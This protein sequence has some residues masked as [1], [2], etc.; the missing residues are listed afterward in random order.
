MISVTILTYNSQKHLKEVLGA[1][2]QFDQVIILD[3][4]SNDNTLSIAEQFPNVDIHSTNLPG[5]GP[6]HNQASALARN[7]WILSLDSDEVLTPDLVEELLGLELDPQYVYSV[8]MNNYFNGK[9]IRCCGWYP[10]RHVRLYNRKRTS[11]TDA[12]VH[13]GIIIAGVTEK[14]LKH[15]V[16]HYS[17][18]SISDFLVKMERYTSL[19]AEQNRGRKK[20]SVLKALGHGCFAFLK[21]YFLQKG[22][23]YGYEGMVIA[24]YQGNTA[25]YKYLKL[26]EANRR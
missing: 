5:F 4:G 6:K 3:S 23:L 21:A 22:C 13:E 9:H 19:F 11:F 18:D 14:F 17:Y 24:A 2:Q 10:D 25:F 20:S 1:V 8:P 15:P 16:C 12:F 7:D 26:L